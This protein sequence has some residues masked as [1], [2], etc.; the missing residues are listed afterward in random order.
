MTTTQPAELE[1]VDRAR[2]LRARLLVANAY[3]LGRSRGYLDLGGSRRRRVIARLEDEVHAAVDAVARDL[4]SSSTL[5]TPRDA[6]EAATAPARADVVAAFRREARARI[7]RTSNRDRDA[8][9][10]NA[11]RRAAVELGG[12]VREPNLPNLIGRE[13][14]AVLVELEVPGAVAE[15][16][17][18][19]ELER[20][21][22]RRRGAGTVIA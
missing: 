21:R 12:Q 20:I 13:L 6:V 8:S 22:G 18:A 11:L 16:G 7:A 4:A 1:R 3:D 14:A 9:I 15:L 19:G 17:L 5:D 2:E 10:R